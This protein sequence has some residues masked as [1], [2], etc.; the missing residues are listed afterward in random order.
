MH[1]GAGGDDPNK[2]IKENLLGSLPAGFIFGQNVNNL[3][4][5]LT[6]GYPISRADADHDTEADENDGKEVVLKAFEHVL[7]PLVLI[8]RGIVILVSGG[9]FGR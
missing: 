5:S 2:L 1:L 9:A 3:L 6:V 7:F 4:S 8:G